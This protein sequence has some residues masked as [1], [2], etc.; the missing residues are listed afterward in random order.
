RRTLFQRMSMSGWWLAASGRSASRLTKARA[1]AKTANLYSLTISPPVSSH[2]AS[3]PTALLA[4]VSYTVAIVRPPRRPAQPAKVTRYPPGIPET[5]RCRRPPP[6][7]AP[8]MAPLS[9]GGRPTGG[10]RGPY[11]PGREPPGSRRRSAPR[12]RPPARRGRGAGAGHGR[13]HRRRAALSAGAEAAPRAGGAARRHA[14]V[15]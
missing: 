14:R 10:E 9:A 13:P 11:T 8:A 2:P 1:P 7:H 4:S 12:G 15:L 5:P 6:G 3:P